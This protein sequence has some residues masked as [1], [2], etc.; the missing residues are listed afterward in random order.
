MK[1]SEILDPKA[2]RIEAYDADHFRI[3]GQVF[4]HAV[5]LL[6]PAEVQPWRSGPASTITGADL[7]PLFNARPQVILIGTGANHCMP[8]PSLMA[9][10]TERGIGIEWMRTGAA[11]RT[12]NLLASEGR[13]V[14]TGLLLEHD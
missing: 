6:P 1:F 4:A 12:Y 14:A 8:P 10:A 5:L 13:R 11:C 3:S 9:A 2:L 7:E